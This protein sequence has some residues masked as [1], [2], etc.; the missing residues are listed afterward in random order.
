MFARLTHSLC[1]PLLI[2]SK[3][4]LDLRNRAGLEFIKFLIICAISLLPSG[5]EKLEE[6]DDVVMRI[7]PKAST[8]DI[9]NV[10]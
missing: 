3:Y 7:L 9:I 2:V 5:L 8:V 10:L 6:K 1:Y 4:L